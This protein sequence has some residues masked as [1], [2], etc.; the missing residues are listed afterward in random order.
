MKLPIAL[1]AALVALG[2]AGCVVSGPPRGV[3][4]V[5]VGVRPPPPRV[6]VVPAPRRG[7]VWA[8]GFW[9]WDGHRHVWVDGHWM[10]ARRGWSWAPAHWEERRGGWHF[11]PGLWVRVGR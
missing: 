4:V 5:D 10:R 1:L 7:Y 3:A 8:A 6:V 2:T 11:V 9:R